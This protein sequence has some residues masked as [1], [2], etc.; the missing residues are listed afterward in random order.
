[1]VPFSSIYQE[2]EP[3]GRHSTGQELLALT[4]RFFRLVLRKSLEACSIQSESNKRM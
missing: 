3:S 1:M 4:A 2:G